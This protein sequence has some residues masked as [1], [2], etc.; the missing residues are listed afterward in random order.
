MI[1]TTLFTLLLLQ[2]TICGAAAQV[3]V[4]EISPANGT[5]LDRNHASSDWLEL[6][7]ISATVNLKGWRISDKNN[8]DKAYIL[9]DTVLNQGQS[10]MVFCTQDKNTHP[11]TTL[12]GDAAWIGRWSSW[13]RNTFAYMPLSGDFTMTVR[14][15][16]LHHDSVPT[17]AVLLLRD[18]TYETSRY[19]GIAALSNKTTIIHQKPSTN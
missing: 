9:P 13:E 5:I 15:N 16:S 11:V 18:N 3:I 6:T 8:F 1:K 19:I 10:A 4:T 17:E 12:I 7:A 14:I 2:W